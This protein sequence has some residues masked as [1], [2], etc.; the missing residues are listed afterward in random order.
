MGT[1]AGALLK[2]LQSY[3]YKLYDMTPQDGKR[4]RP[5]EPADLLAAHPVDSF[6]SQTDLMLLRDGREPP[7][8]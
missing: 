7:R 2:T 4:L 5:T 3:K 8:E 6:G 1:D